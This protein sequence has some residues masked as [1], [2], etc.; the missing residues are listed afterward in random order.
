MTDLSRL[1]IVLAV[2]QL[3]RGG[4]ERQVC[5]LGLG[6][7]ALGA[8]VSVVVL[9][10]GGRM[11]DA[12]IDADIAVHHVRMGS[13]SAG[14][15]TSVLSLVAGSWRMRRLLDEVKPDVV[16]CFLPRACTVVPPIARSRRTPLV[17]G[18]RRGLED[19]RPGGRVHHAAEL[20]ASRWID[21]WVANCPEVA[22]DTR[23]AMRADVRPVLVVPNALDPCFLSSGDD[24]IPGGP[25]TV[26]CI[27]NLLPVKRHD[28]LLAAMAR[29]SLRRFD[30]ELVLVGDGPLRADILEDARR[31]GIRVSCTGSVDDV[32]P[33]LRRATVVVLASDSEGVSNALMEAMATRRPI[34]ATAVGGNSSLLAGRGTTVPAGDVSALAAAIESVLHDPA[35]AA[36]VADAAAAWIRTQAALPVV[37]QRQLDIYRAALSHVSAAAPSMRG[38]A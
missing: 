26:V 34:V 35:P 25:P 12:L 38:A 6:L 19:Q 13:R 11:G 31:R 18:G 21:L 37:A 15:A 9:H 5:L 22:A 28:L 17:V 30:P 10:D 32:R 3:T 4:T 20:W 29:P 24:P 7:K 27:A 33:W 14:R 23:A 36:G 1:R 16:H 2:G 8:E